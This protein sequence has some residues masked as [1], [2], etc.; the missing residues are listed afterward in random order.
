MM[1]E[2]GKDERYAAAMLLLP[3]PLAAAALLLFFVEF[4]EARAMPSDAAIRDARADA[5]PLMMP[6]LPLMR[7]AFHAAGAEGFCACAASAAQQRTR[8]AVM[9]IF[10]CFTPASGAYALALRFTT[11]C[12]PPPSAM[13]LRAAARRRPSVRAPRVGASR[14]LLRFAPLFIFHAPA[15]LPRRDASCCF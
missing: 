5:L 4:A 2:S 13:P 12:S 3:P 1:L 10:A 9:I 7:I 15:C 11:R 8:D 14:A 6:C